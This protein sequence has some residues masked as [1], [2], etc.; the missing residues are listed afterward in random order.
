MML[1]LQCD[2]PV[3]VCGGRDYADGYTV[4]ATLD[5]L[6]AIRPI[7]VIIEG[8]A[9]GADSLAERW[10]RDTMIPYLGVPAQ[11][12]KYGKGAGPVRNQQML[13]IIRP[14][15]CVAFPGGNGTADMVA[16]CKKAG[17]YVHEIIE[18]KTPEPP[19]DLSRFQKPLL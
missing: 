10:A 8:A 16:R 15:V 19:P 3:L 5:S 4:R 17:V 9:K 6:L 13:D 7:D 18:P 2:F 12:D 1:T 11:W 14:K